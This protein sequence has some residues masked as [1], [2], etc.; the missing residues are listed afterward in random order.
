MRGLFNN[1][2]LY[3]FSANPFTEMEEVYLDE[4]GYYKDTSNT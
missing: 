1:R 4:E 2:A 3:S